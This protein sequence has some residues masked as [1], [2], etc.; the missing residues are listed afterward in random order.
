[1]SKMSWHG[2]GPHIWP[3]SWI[4]KMSEREVWPAHSMYK[5]SKIARVKNIRKA[6]LKF[7]THIFEILEIDDAG[8]LC[9]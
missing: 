1:M 7:R 6:Q 3:A 2:S 5:M 9:V 8:H 4:S